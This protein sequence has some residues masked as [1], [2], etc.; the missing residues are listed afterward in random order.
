MTSKV[1]LFI[2]CL[3]FG[4]LLGILPP[5]SSAQQNPNPQYSVQEFESLKKRVSELEKQLQTVENVEKMELQAKLAEANA[6]LLNAEFAKLERDLRDSNDEWLRTWSHWFL[7]IISAFITILIGVST[8]FWFWLKSRADRRIA[9]EVEK[10]LNGFRQALDEVCTQKKDLKKLKRDHAEA[11]LENYIDDSLPYERNHPKQVKALPEDVLLAM[12]DD[13]RESV[14]LRCKTAE[15]LVARNFPAMDV[16]LL[17]LLDSVHESNIE[18]DIDYF[19]ME[20]LMRSFLEFLGQNPTSEVCEGLLKFLNRLLRE[21]SQYRDVLVTETTFSL[22]NVSIAL[23]NE[24]PVPILRRAI[25]YLRVGEESSKALANLASCFNEFN[26][27]KATEELLIRHGESLSSDV[28]DKCLELL[29]KHDPEF[30]EKWRTQNKPDG[31]E[32]S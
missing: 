29:N 30:V 3:M 24:N 22:A 27:P 21:D 7:V 28:V 11:I 9:D 20:R 13:D 1:K 8:I 25:L 19:E 26:E 31:T 10:N 16:P 32:S 23:N 18:L 12:L 2:T 6:K 17:K 5:P 4:S 15:I 14:S